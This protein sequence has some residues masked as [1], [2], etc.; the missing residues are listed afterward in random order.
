MG[1]EDTVSCQV[2]AGGPLSQPLPKTPTRQKVLNTLASSLPPSWSQTEREGT[3]ERRGKSERE[4]EP[5]SP[6][7]MKGPAT[8]SLLYSLCQLPSHTS[9]C[10]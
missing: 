4:A 7:I 9:S 10:S 3:M 6:G 5:G 2:A 1:T 8:W